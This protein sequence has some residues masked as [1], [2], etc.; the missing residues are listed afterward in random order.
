[1]ILDPQHASPL[2][3]ILEKVI[4]CLDLH[5][6]SAA[7][8]LRPNASSPR[9]SAAFVYRCRL[10]VVNQG[11]HLSYRTSPSLQNGERH[12]QAIKLGRQTRHESHLVWQSARRPGRPTRAL[13]TIFTKMPSTGHTQWSKHRLSFQNQK[14]DALR[15]RCIRRAISS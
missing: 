12:T 7:P 5:A 6:A 1:M 11:L 2:P 14:T 8:T 9:Q 10:L 4:Q 3:A 13:G 15:Q